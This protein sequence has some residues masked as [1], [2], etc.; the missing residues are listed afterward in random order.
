[1]NEGGQ[2]PI[3]VWAVLVVP[4]VPVAVSLWARDDLSIRFVVAYRFPAV[5]LTA[6][7]VLPAPWNV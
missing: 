2:R 6:L 7:G 1:M 4:F 5:V 3:A